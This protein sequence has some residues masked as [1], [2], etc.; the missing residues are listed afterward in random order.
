MTVLFENGTANGPSPNTA[1]ADGAS[2]VFTATGNFDGASVAVQIRS[3][4]DPNAEWVT[5]TNGVMSGAGHK[6][7]EFIPSGYDIRANISSAG[8]ST[9]VFAEIR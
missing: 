5:V 1:K 7:V 3:T 4:D 9:D 6:L 2:K 8:A